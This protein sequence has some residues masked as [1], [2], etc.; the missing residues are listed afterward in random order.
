[1]TLASNLGVTRRD[2]DILK[3]IAAG[4][5]NKAIANRLNVSPR[6]VRGR[7]E[8][9]F[10]RFDIHSRANAAALYTIGSFI[11]TDAPHDAAAPAAGG[12]SR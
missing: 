6:L 10:A 5:P 3:L 11:V 9:L 8:K 7:V 12:S 2:H 4:L 1:M